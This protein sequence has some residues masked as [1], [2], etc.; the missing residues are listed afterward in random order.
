MSSSILASYKQKG[1]SAEVKMHLIVGDRMLSVGQLG[2]DFLL[3]D[4]P[5]DHPPGTATLFF[6]VDGEP[7]ERQV[8]LPEGIS[9]AQQR[10]LIAS[11]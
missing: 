7:R 5:V 1:H 4:E 9:A 3:L 11:A 8:Y 2:P 6:S 10:V